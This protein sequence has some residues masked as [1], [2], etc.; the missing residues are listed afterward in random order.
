MAQESYYYC[1]GKKVFLPKNERVRYVGLKNSLTEKQA[2]SIRENLSD[3][4]TMVYEHTPFF[5]KFFISEDKIEQ[6][7]GVIHNNDSLIS[8]NSPNYAPEDTLMLYPTR[9]ILVKV[10]PS[11]SLLSVLDNMEVPY[12]NVIQ[13]KYNGQEYRISLSSDVALQFAALLYETG[14]FEYAQPNF[15]EEEYSTGYQ[16]NPEYQYQW[17][18]HNNINMNLLP[19]WNI[20]TGHPQV[21]VAVLDDGVDLN[22]PDL[23]ENLLEGYDAVNDPYHP[24]PNCCCGENESALDYHGTLCTGVIGASNNEEGLVGVAHTSKVI[25]IRIF[26]TV[27]E[28]FKEIPPEDPT[29]H[30]VLVGDNSW[31]IDAFDHACYEDKADV[32][33]C[34]FTTGVNDGGTD[35]I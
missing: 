11:I 20:T 4:C 15:C 14:L 34:S 25:P 16:D 21:K 3:C 29:Y 7:D 33:S 6:F 30:H 18:V 19:A 9:T 17:A 10:K 5:A 31:K 1:Q 12:D 22:H 24:S 23:T 13:S 27:L 8:L 32:I 35:D 2:K 26:H 28:Y